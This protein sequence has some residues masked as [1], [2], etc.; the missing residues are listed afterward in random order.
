MTPREIVLAQIHHQEPQPV[1]YTLGFE[2]DVAERYFDDP[3][4][5]ND[6]MHATS[7]DGKITVYVL[8]N[9]VHGEHKSLTSFVV[10]GRDRVTGQDDVVFGEEHPV[11]VV[12]KS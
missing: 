12:E 9:D 1:P 10:K 2:G 11:V 6:Y 8:L 7:A 3:K 5:G 4:L